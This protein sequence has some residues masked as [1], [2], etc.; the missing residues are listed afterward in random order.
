MKQ[1][2]GR[3]QDREVIVEGNWVTSR[4]PDDLPA[5]NNRELLNLLSALPGRV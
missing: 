5:F 1:P 3:W 4:K 2:W